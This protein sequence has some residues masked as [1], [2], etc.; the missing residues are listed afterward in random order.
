MTY[1]FPLS[2]LLSGLCAFAHVPSFCPSH[3]FLKILSPPLGSLSWIPLLFWQLI[4]H[5][6]WLETHNSVMWLLLL[7]LT[8]IALLLLPSRLL[9]RNWIIFMFEA[10]ALRIYKTQYTYN[11]RTTENIKSGDAYCLSTSYLFCRIGTSLN[12][13][14]QWFH[15]CSY[16]HHLKL[17]QIK[18]VTR[19]YQI[20]S[21]NCEEQKLNNAT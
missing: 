2:P 5:S 13:L 14:C 11:E 18:Q 15:L 7:I 19:L 3:L 1:S 8:S 20:M 16:S 17:A 12:F 21:A 6:L 9:H 4:N 10:R